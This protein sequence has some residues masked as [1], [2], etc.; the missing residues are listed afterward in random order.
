MQNVFQAFRRGALALATETMAY[1]ETHQRYGLS[2]DDWA[3][4]TQKEPWNVDQR[5]RV[6]SLISECVTISLTVAGLPAQSLPAQYVAAV[7]AT[8]VSPANLIVAAHAAPESYDA[9]GAANVEQTF[10]VTPVRSE[11]M[12][13][14]IMLYAGGFG[15]EPNANV[16]GQVD[17]SEDK[18]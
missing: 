3:L 5:R 1:T 14:L 2:Q 13:S 10:Q 15:S 18:K 17:L 4:L 9:T 6:R 12:L 16:T 11:Q 7:I 8:I